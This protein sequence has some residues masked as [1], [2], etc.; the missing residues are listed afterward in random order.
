M[1]QTIS[2]WREE[3]GLEH[4]REAHPASKGSERG[5]GRRLAGAQRLLCAP[6]TALLCARAV[7]ADGWAAPSRQAGS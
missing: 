7:G 5:N 6:I 3:Q 1:G 2:E 4:Q